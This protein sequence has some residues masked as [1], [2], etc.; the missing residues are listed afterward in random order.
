MNQSIPN[1]ARLAALE[2]IP[3]AA[4][5]MGIS[6]STFYRELKNGRYPGPLIKLGARSSAVP[7]AATDSWI[8]ARIAEAAKAEDAR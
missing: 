3:A 5:R 1:P 7:V 6:I 8:A 4:S 2:K